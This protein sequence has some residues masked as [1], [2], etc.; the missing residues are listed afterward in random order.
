MVLHS[1]SLINYF[2]RIYNMGRESRNDSFLIPLH[3]LNMSIYPV[4]KIKPLVGGRC[5]LYVQSIVAMYDLLDTARKLGVTQ[6]EAEL[7]GL[8]CH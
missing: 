5:E 7:Y 4:C 1:T 3:L 6:R 2:R 8:S